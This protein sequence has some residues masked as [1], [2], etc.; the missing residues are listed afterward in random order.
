MTPERLSELTAQ[1]ITTADAV[2][3]PSKEI[4]KY[5]EPTSLAYLVMLGR[6][7]SEE[8]DRIGNND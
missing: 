8:L 5:L 7:A 6:R 1:A 4:I 3:L 2:C